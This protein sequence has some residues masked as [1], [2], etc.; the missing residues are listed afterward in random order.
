MINKKFFRCIVCNDIHWGYNAPEICPTCLN[1][2]A[3]I[4]I[5]EKEAK[6]IFDKIIINK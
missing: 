2:N 3:Y 5:E 6:Y 1:K 4:E